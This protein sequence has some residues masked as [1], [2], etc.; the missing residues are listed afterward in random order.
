MVSMAQSL[1][2]SKNEVERARLFDELIR[3]QTAPLVRKILRQS[4]GFYLNLDGRSANNPEAEELYN[5]ILRRLEQ[6]LRDLLAEPEQ[7]PIDDYR[8][9]VINIA[10]GECEDFLRA[11]SGSRAHLKNN[12]RGMIRRHSEF[13]VWEGD[14]GRLLCGFATWEGRRISIAS[15][16]RLAQLKANPESFKSKRF[17]YKSLQK[18]PYPKFVAELFQWLGDPIGFEDLVEL[19]PLFRQINDRPAEPIGLAKKDQELQPADPAPPAS[20]RPEK[21]QA[22][23]DLEKPQT[24]AGLEKKMSLKQLWE[25]LKQLPP[26]SR[27]ILCLSPVGE[28]CDDLWDLLLAADVVTLAELADGLEIPLE[29][30]TEIWLRAPV[31]SRTLADYLGATTSQVNKWRFQAVKHLRERYV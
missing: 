8:Q 3:A 20:D 10:T 16:E 15:S 12:L 21:P 19:I 30:I 17:T 29:Q 25:E 5:R 14:D 4:L 18:A 28:E 7:H 26:E 27:L 1:L 11:K 23:G 13:K 24:G 9:C 31:N 2:G 22:G 6:R